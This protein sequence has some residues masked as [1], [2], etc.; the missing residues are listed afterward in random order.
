MPRG[1]AMLLIGLSVGGVAAQTDA[2]PW[3]TE[4]QQAVA[5]AQRT[6]RPLMVYVLA[7]SK[8]RDNNI[9]REHKR[10]FADPRVLRQAQNFIPLRLSRSVHRDVLKD[11]GLSESAN[12]QMSF[13]APDGQVLGDLSAGGVGQP[14][15]L[16][17]KLAAAFDA[18]RKKLYDERVKPA[19]TA[20]D[21]KPA[22]INAALQMALEFRLAAAEADVIALLDQPRLDAA[23]RS[24]AFDLLAAL[25]SNTAVD[26]LIELTRA[27]DTRAAAAL[28][29]C[30]PPAAERIFAQLNAETE[31]FEYPL[32]KAVT[33]ICGIRNVK[34]ARYFEKAK[35]RLKQQ[36]LER[37]GKLVEQ[38][39]QRWKEENDAAR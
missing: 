10:A 33:K 7:S 3:R 28:E 36:E 20:T 31:P 23:G 15:S 27:G 9:E 32:Y 38:A 4:P 24:T 12:M 13:V 30:A 26:K 11:F 29:K 21:T 22:D 14:D 35:P 19:L 6:M 17:A 39:V 18:Y 16:A 2:I 37:V 34:V 25:S 1:V 8:D 5:E